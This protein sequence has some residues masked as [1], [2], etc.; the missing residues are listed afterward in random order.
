MEYWIG[1]LGQSAIIA[2]GYISN[3]K[4]DEIKFYNIL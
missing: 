3:V 4:E 1:F 2:V